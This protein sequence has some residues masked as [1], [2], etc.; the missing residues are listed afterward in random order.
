MNPAD[1]WQRAADEL[2]AA[3]H[4]PRVH[5]SD[6]LLAI[7]QAEQPRIDRLR[8]EEELN[9]FAGEVEVR[10]GDR[11]GLDAVMQAVGS[12]PEGTPSVSARTEKARHDLDAL[13]DVLSTARG[14]RGDDEDYYDPAN[15]LLDR[16]LERRRGMPILLS[17]LY[18]EVARRA[19]IP[20]VGVAL[21]GHFLVRHA[22]AASPLFAD[23]WSGGRVLRIA[24]LQSILDQMH[25]G[26][27][28][29]QPA[30]LTP[31][32][33]HEIV[34]RVLR[35]LKASHLRRNEF[36]EAFGVTQVIVRLAPEDP[37]EWW[38]RGRIRLQLGDRLGALEDFGQCV[39]AAP[40]GPLRPEAEKA[41]ASIRLSFLQQN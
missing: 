9:R 37:A 35:N 2:A 16:V 28:K 23:P 22:A 36:T 26:A 15:S 17:C 14:F 40:T 33:P 30:M 1:G 21:P 27:V 10:L 20:L 39:A 7:A 8:I 41:I 24:D 3:L 18:C 12:S 29:L 31:A 6:L 13:A 25:R 4:K 19:R 11:H 32:R 38:D 34:L 5:L